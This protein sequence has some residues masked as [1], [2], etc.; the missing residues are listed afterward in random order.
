MEAGLACEVGHLHCESGAH[1]GVPHDP[2]RT[3]ASHRIRLGDRENAWNVYHHNDL[4]NE[5]SQNSCVG[6]PEEGGEQGLRPYS[7]RHVSSWHVLLARHCHLHACVD[8]G[9]CHSLYPY[10]GDC[11]GRGRGRGRG[12]FALCLFLVPGPYGTCR[13]NGYVCR[14]CRGYDLTVSYRQILVHGAYH[15]GLF[16]LTATDETCV[17]A[18]CRTSGP[19]NGR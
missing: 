15:G 6:C 1:R 9:L 17:F 10:R 14:V 3:W 2:S 18:E 11:V 19:G 5:P 4:W 12:A 7:P 13:A 16:P 8:D